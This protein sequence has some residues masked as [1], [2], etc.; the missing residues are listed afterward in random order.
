MVYL[1]ILS[2]FAFQIQ[3]SNLSWKCRNIHSFNKYLVI[4]Y[5]G[6]QSE[7]EWTCVYAQLN[8]FAVQR[9]FSQHCKSAIIHQ[10]V[11]QFIIYPYVCSQS[12][13]IEI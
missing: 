8:H 7:K 1:E 4:I 13:E 11:I 9:R 2:T 12:L 3:V 5:M 6:R 10:H